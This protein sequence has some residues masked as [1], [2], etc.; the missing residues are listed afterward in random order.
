MKH[1]YTQSTKTWN[2]SSSYK[3]NRHWAPDASTSK[4]KFSQKDYC[5][6]CS[7][8]LTHYATTHKIVSGFRSVCCIPR[9]RPRDEKFRVSQN[10]QWLNKA[11]WV[12]LFGVPI[13]RYLWPWSTYNRHSGIHWI[14]RGHNYCFAWKCTPFNALLATKTFWELNVIV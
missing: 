5:S 4:F 6:R 12:A 10:P 1:M 11:L 14:H 3:N 7:T 9:N 8:S 2:T 13:P